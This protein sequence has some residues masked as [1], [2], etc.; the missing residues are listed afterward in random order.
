[1]LSPASLKLAAD[2]Q[3]SGETW[4]ELTLETAVEARELGVKARYILD[5]RVDRVWIFSLRS[6]KRLTVP[7][8]SDAEGLG[9]ALLLRTD[10]LNKVG[11]E[12]GRDVLDGVKPMLISA[13]STKLSRELA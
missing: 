2:Q 7:E 4:E 12:L 8:L 13:Q 6:V 3:F 11:D 9:F 5:K 1:M 10:A